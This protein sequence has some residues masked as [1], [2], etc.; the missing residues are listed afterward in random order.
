MYLMKKKRIF[1]QTRF[2]AAGIA[3]NIVFLKIDSWK[4]R[5]KIAL[6]SINDIPV[7]SG[8]PVSIKIMIAWCCVNAECVWPT[9]SFDKITQFQSWMTH[10]VE[11]CSGW[12]LQL[13]FYQKTKNKLTDVKQ[14]CNVLIVLI[15]Q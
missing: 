5:R 4:M 13:E 7:A 11:P 6:H 14:S 1:N 3:E 10:D 12:K 9:V 2:L 15:L 8:K